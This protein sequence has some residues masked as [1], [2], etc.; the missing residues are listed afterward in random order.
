MRV[1]LVLTLLA[2]AA[3]ATYAWA[4]TALTVAIVVTTCGAS[5]LYIAGHDAP[6]T[7]DTTGQTC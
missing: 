6:L 1:L 5:T 7:V 3:Y 2:G 4:S